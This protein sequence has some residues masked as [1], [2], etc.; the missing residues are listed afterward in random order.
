MPHEVSRLLP[1]TL[2]WWFHYWGPCFITLL[3]IQRSFCCCHTLLPEGLIFIS[4]SLFLTY[5]LRLHFHSQLVHNS[6]L[7]FPCSQFP[8]KNPQQFLL[9]CFSPFFSLS[10]LFLSVIWPNSHFL[11]KTFLEYPIA[12]DLSCI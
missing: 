1:H 5:H 9:K 2:L 12:S 4:P 11:L 10:Q 8:I 6:P 7:I 3:L